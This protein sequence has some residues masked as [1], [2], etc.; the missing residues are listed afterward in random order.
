MNIKIISAAVLATLALSS[1]STIS[2]TASTVG[3]DTKVFSL[4]VADMNVAKEK[5]SATAEWSWNPLSNVSLKEQKKSAE[6]RL[7][8]ESGADVL[9]EPR[10]EVKR[11]GFMRGGSVT[12]SGYPATYA[13]FR[14]MTESDAQ[15]VA[16]L[17]GT[18]RMVDP[19]IGTTWSAPKGRKVKAPKKPK[20]KGLTFGEKEFNGR[21]FVALVGGPLIDVDDTHFKTSTSAGAMYGSYGSRWGWYGKFQ[22]QNV[23]GCSNSGYVNGF[24]LT[25]G[26]I[27]TISHNVNVLLGT[28]I[29]TGYD[30][31]EWGDD[32]EIEIG[33]FALPIDLMF[34]WSKGSFTLLGGCMA[35]ITLGDVRTVHLTPTIGIGYNF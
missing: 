8:K 11:R 16:T 31:D 35:Q 23:K 17:D 2:H 22:Y 12:V 21:K 14:R 15:T 1:C 7:L 33:S 13:N 32:S 27:K 6:A 28:G 3:V 34:Q 29:S 25:F 10:Y 20:V 18:M 30:R 24:A 9:V 4:T 5:V 19:V 26:A